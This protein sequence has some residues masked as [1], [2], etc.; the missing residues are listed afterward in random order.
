[1]N[2]TTCK[3]VAIVGIIIAALIVL[4]LLAAVIRCCCLGVTCIQALFCCCNCCNCCDNGRRRSGNESYQGGPYPAP[5]ITV[6]NHHYRPNSPPQYATVTDFE[7]QP[8]VPQKTGFM[9]S[10]TG[11]QKLNDTNNMELNSMNTVPSYT[12]HPNVNTAYNPN[13]SNSYDNTYS[14]YDNFPQNNYN[15]SNTGYY[16]NRF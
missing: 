4:W 10:N 3:W 1:M 5:N 6:Q 7:P 13:H 9:G 16:N 14:D 2:N 12:T 15:G 11:Y 8:N